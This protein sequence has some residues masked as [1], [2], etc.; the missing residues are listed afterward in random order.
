MAIRATGGFTLLAYEPG[1]PQFP[2]LPD[3]VPT[4]H[5][6]EWGT[7]QGLARRLPIPYGQRV[8]ASAPAGDDQYFAGWQTETTWINPYI[9][10]FGVIPSPV[11]RTVN[12]YNARSRPITVTALS[13]P[14][15]VTLVSP[16]LPVT[17]QPF[18]GDEFT[19]E[20]GTTG[21]NS[22]DQIENFT[23]SEGLVPVRF[24]GRRI[25]NIDVIPEVAMYETLSWKTD[26]IRAFDGVEK[27]YSLLQSP[28]TRVEYHVKFR[29]DIE[30]IKFRNQFIAGESALVVAGQKWYELRNL[31]NDVQTTDTTLDI[32]IPAPKTWSVEAQ[33]P[34][35]LVSQSGVVKN[36]ICQSWRYQPD[37]FYG[38]NVVVARFDGTDGQTTGIT[39]LIDGQEFTFLFDTQIDTSQSVFGGSSLLCTPLNPGFAAGGAHLDY[40]A[41]NTIMDFGSDWTIDFWFRPTAG[42]ITAGNTLASRWYSSDPGAR[43]WR[44]EITGSGA[45]I[46][47]NTREGGF[48]RNYTFTASPLPIQADTWHYCRLSCTADVVSCA[49]DGNELGS[50]IALVGTINGGDIR[51]VIGDYYD[52][53]FTED[54]KGHIDDF[55]LTIG[56]GRDISEVPTVAHP[57]EEEIYV[58]LALGA[59][60]GTAFNAG[61]YIMPVGLG[62]VSDFPRYNTHPRNLEETKYTL[63]FNQEQEVAGLDTA[64][65]P[66]L[67]D[68]QSPTNTLPVLD[69]KN[70]IDQQAKLTLLDRQE[71]V[72]DSGLSNRLAFTQYPFADEISDFMITLITPEDIWAWRTFLGYLRGSYGEFYIPTGTND[73]PG[74]TTTTGTTFDVEDTDAAL[75]FGNPPDPRRNAIMLVYPDGTRLYRT[76]TQII[77]NGA[78]EEFTVNSSLIAGNPEISYLQRAR[79]LGD[80]ALFTHFRND[81]SVLRFQYRTIM[82]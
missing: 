41:G 51:L 36:T 34:I 17:L 82:R 2:T 78:T 31:L 20:A 10:D 73:L 49:I 8:F 43:A 14:T 27:A 15:G 24:I 54:F 59:E 6:H 76:I 58:E 1:N 57:L 30:R 38:F 26:L 69:F 45:G 28:N 65:F 11:R 80:T 4:P 9:V 47:F 37:E 7:A 16:T 55:R 53:G 42:D 81:Y 50:A 77:D 19:L 32:D 18:G 75:L 62:Y 56:Y 3:G 52:S 74:A 61:D 5:V 29:N 66:T 40:G 21:D 39:N 25:F 13:L 63:V 70:E 12:L 60:I 35:S 22:F 44:V 72:L 33:T 67:D 68:L 48:S 46:N 79:I 23:T 64:Y 71:D